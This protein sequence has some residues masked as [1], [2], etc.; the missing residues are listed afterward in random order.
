MGYWTLYNRPWSCLK[1]S[2]TLKFKDRN[3]VYSSQMGVSAQR[4]IV[5]HEW[6][7]LQH[8][9]TLSQECI[10]LCVYYVCMYVCICVL[11]VC[12]WVWERENICMHACMPV[13]ILLC[14]YVCVCLYIYVYRYN[15]YIIYTGCPGGNVPDFGRMFLKLKYT[16]VSQ[17]TYIRS[18]TLTE[19]MAREVWM[20]DICY[21]LID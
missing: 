11:Y 9:Y 13:C 12:V 5:T 18:W 6:I 21:T 19:I 17:N 3:S 10:Y 15:I 8:I 2:E 20:Y 14:T 1:I 16:E 7:V 4:I